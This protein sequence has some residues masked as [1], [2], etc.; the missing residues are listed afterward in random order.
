MREVAEM[1]GFRVNGHTHK[2]LCPFHGDKNPSLLCYPGKRGWFCFVC[3]QGGSVLDFV[4]LLFGLDFIDA[5]KKLNEDFQLGLAIGETLTDDQKHEAAL[6][7]RKRRA[8][9]ERQQAEEKVLFTAYHAALDRFTALDRI[10]IENEPQDPF[11]ELS[12]KYCYA[13]K[14]LDA[15]WNDVQEASEKLR[16]FERK[17]L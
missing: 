4:M 2:I 1:Y 11:S 9:M 5:C 3:N 8:E 16:R 17:T 10:A 6:A 13:A 14:R 15:A 7:I 12:P